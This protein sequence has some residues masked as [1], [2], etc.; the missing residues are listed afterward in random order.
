M[1]MPLQ[2]QKLWEA[3]I[4]TN[5]VKTTAVPLNHKKIIAT[6]G[7]SHCKSRLLVFNA[8]RGSEGSELTVE[9]Y[10]Q[11]SSEVDPTV[12]DGFTDVERQLLT[13]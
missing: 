5:L 4:N 13:R 2:H 6:I 10:N 7:L 11:A 9:E 8:R 3:S 12:S 1:K